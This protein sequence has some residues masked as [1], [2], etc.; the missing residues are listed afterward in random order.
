MN[1]D[2]DTFLSLGLTPA[3]QR[4]MVFDQFKEGEVNRAREIALSAAGKGVNVAMALAG[5]GMRAWMTGFNGGDSGRTVEA[6]AVKRGAISALTRIRSNTRVCDTIVDQSTGKVTELVEEAPPIEAPDLARF[7]RSALALLRRCCGLAISGTV[8]PALAQQNI[9]VPFAELA[10]KR[11]IPWVIDSHRGDLLS[12]LP[13]HPLVAKMNRH[14]LE[15][16]FDQA[17]TSEALI[18]QQARRLTA[19]GARHAFI[20]DGPRPSW[21]V[22]ADGKAWKIFPPDVERIVNPIGSGDCVTAAM[23]ASLWRGKTPLYAARLGLACGSANIVTLI[24][25]RFDMKL[26]GQLLKAT[27]AERVD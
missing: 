24:P 1:D 18:V 16:T 23:L 3:L 25:A 22:S 8:P 2:T 10:E 20:T 21:L 12:V 6:D 19:A 11:A 14:E 15:V 7:Q 4:T 5:L 9:Y 17:C 27:V 13:Y 26:V